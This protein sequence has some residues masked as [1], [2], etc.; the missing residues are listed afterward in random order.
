[1]AQPS[2]SQL[3]RDVRE[4][5]ANVSLRT[6]VDPRETTAYVTAVASRLVRLQGNLLLR[7]ILV[8]PEADSAGAATPQNVRSIA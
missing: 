6:F 2:P 4:T 8:V 7:A 5:V 3:A 1:M